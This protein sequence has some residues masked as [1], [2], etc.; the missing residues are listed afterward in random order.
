M[1]DLSSKLSTYFLYK[2][3]TFRFQ[4]K[5]PPACPN[6]YH[7]AYILFMKPQMNASDAMILAM[8]SKKDLKIRR[9]RQVISK[10]KNRFQDIA[11]K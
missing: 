9:I 11:L 8:Y 4:L 1:Q 5:M 2:T 10:K 3:Q 6:I 7:A